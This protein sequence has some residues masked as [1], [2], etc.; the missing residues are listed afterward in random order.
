VLT[1]PELVDERTS[2]VC[3]IPKLICCRGWLGYIFLETRVLCVDANSSCHLV[4]HC[5]EVERYSA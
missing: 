2:G 1:P 4:R 3:L 5:S